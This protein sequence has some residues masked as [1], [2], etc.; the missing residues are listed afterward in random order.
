MRYF[1]TFIFCCYQAD[2]GPL[3]Q[4]VST[5]DPQPRGPWPG[6]EFHGVSLLSFSIKETRCTAAAQLRLEFVHF[7]MCMNRNSLSWK[8]VGVGTVGNESRYG[9]SETSELAVQPS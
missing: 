7:W 1:I 3:Y 9:A 5:A 4:H 8:V 2:D 6:P